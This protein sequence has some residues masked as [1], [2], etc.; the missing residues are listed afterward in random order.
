MNL[1]K[2]LR[3]CHE[4]P[5]AI[6]HLLL[7]FVLFKKYKIDVNSSSFHFWFVNVL[8]LKS[9]YALLKKIFIAIFHFHNEMLVW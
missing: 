7:S 5:I 9:I 2:L 1:K 8:F 3:I 6:L 4:F